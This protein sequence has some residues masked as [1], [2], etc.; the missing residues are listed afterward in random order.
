[1]KKLKE[2][3]K[4]LIIQNKWLSYKEKYKHPQMKL[5]FSKVALI[6]NPDLSIKELVS[7]ELEM[8]EANKEKKDEMFVPIFKKLRN[9]TNVKADW[10]AFGKFMWFVF[11]TSTYWKDEKK[12]INNIYTKR[13]YITVNQTKRD[14]FNE[15]LHSI[16][17]NTNNYNDLIIE[18]LK[19]VY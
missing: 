16:D 17:H 4:H 2:I 5:I 8:L 11:Q 3:K 19:K 12:G 7:F 9:L 1:M 6:F 14:L 15:W 10:K 18:T 13:N